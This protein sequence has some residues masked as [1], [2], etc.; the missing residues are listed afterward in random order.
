MTERTR[1]CVTPDE[2]SKYLQIPPAQLPQRTD[3]SA[4][5]AA[6]GRIAISQQAFQ[7]EVVVERKVSTCEQHWIYQVLLGP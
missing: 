4:V 5:S 7:P 6:Q 1:F 3:K 2:D